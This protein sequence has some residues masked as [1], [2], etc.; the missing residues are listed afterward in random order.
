MSHEDIPPDTWP[1]TMPV[2]QFQHWGIPL[3]AGANLNIFLDTN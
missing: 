3:N 1:S 2:Y